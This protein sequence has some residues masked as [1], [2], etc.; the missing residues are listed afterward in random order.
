MNI[1]P[2]GPGWW[3]RGC[4]R[5]YLGRRGHS[6]M[7][8]RYRTRGPCG[9]RTARAASTRPSHRAPGRNH[10]IIFDWLPLPLTSVQWVKKLQP[11]WF[12]QMAWQSKA[13]EMCSTCSMVFSCSS[14]LCREGADLAGPELPAQGLSVGGIS[15]QIVYGG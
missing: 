15:P 14:H 2:R 13:D 1:D 8:T 3:G 12:W 10:L 5:P 9:G 11:G 4:S 6:S 7:A